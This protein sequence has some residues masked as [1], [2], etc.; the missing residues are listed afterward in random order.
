MLACV[1]AEGYCWG[2]FPILPITAFFCNINIKNE[3][4]SAVQGCVLWIGRVE[5]RLSVWMRR[6]PG[7]LIFDQMCFGF[8]SAAAFFS[9]ALF[10]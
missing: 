4:L 7:E 3:Y 5:S 6:G 10:A 9:V 8:N 2:G 1:F